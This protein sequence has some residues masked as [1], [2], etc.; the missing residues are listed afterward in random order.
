MCRITGFYDL[1]Y[2]G[3]YDL[4]D[5]ITSM[6][7][8]MT[9][10]GP[11]DAGIYAEE[12]NGIALGHRRLSIL[13]ISSLGHQ[14]MS[15]NEENLWITYNGEVYNFQEI[16]QELITKGYRFKSNTDTEVVINAYKEWGIKGVDKF[17]G[18]FAFVIWDK[19]EQRF[20]LCRDRVGVKPLYWYY[21]DGLFMFSSE[22]KAFHKHQRFY[23]EMDE[24]AMSL[25]FQ[26]GY[27]PAPYSIFKYAHKLKAGHFL[28]FDKKDGIKEIQ[29]WA[30]KD[31]YL[32]GCDVTA[33]KSEEE[34]E[35]S[36]E[37]ILVDSFKLRL[38]SDVP[39]GIFLSGGI[40]SSI[41]ASLLQSNTGSTLKTYTIG[42]IGDKDY[43][44]AP[45]AKE[46]ASILGTDHTEHYFTEQDIMEIIP[47]I[48][49]LYDEPFADSSA[50]P[51]YL[52]SSIARKYVKV[53]LSADGGDELFCGYNHYCGP[54]FKKFDILSKSLEKIGL[55]EG[56]TNLL[57]T[58]TV[59]R[60]LNVSY[61]TKKNIRGKINLLKYYLD[62][63]RYNKSIDTR[64]IMM[65]IDFIKYLPD[66]ILVKVDR[67]T[68]GVALEGR[69]PFL[70]HKLIEYVSQLPQKY[71]YQNGIQKYILKKILAKYIP[72]RLINRPKWGFG[73]PLDGIYLRPKIIQ[74]C[75]TYLNKKILKRTGIIDFRIANGLLK[76]FADN[77]TDAAM[78]VRFNNH[79]MLWSAL[80]FQM[81]CEKHL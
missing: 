63:A 29:Y 66:D 3:A 60:Y 37:K 41:V 1:N 31:Y 20:I 16:R 30:A 53:A 81:W 22:L 38:I 14:P 49:V 74:L 33:G 32:N 35:G 57:N 25:Y 67:A 8:T 43:D 24:M 52:V 15:D 19:I 51:T 7:D 39:L 68:M 56:I 80:C 28:S 17:R 42:F 79:K 54:P 78:S 73:V 75:D 6:R 77:K 50:L 27:I 76:R 18:M 4:V 69:E 45:Y 10:G 47:K 62:E 34:I 23:K 11:D 64:V 26:L 72:Q 48:P 13:D 40:D 70:D 2:R 46:V 12:K 71:K 9:H 61:P 59:E 44:E 65:Y 21:K 58:S 55:K 36:L 5:T